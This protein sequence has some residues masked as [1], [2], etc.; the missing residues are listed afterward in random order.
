MGFRLVSMF[1]WHWHRGS[2]SL[3]TNCADTLRELL[4]A[5]SKQARFAKALHYFDKNG[6]SV[7]LSYRKLYFNESIT[8][9]PRKC[10][11]K[12]FEWAVYEKNASST[13][14][15]QAISQF[16]TGTFWM[17]TAIVENEYLKEITRWFPQ[18][19]N[20]YHDKLLFFML[21]HEAWVDQTLLC[22]PC[23]TCPQGSPVILLSDLSLDHM[24]TNPPSHVLEC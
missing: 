2:H 5:F 17:G 12:L 14:R 11:V 24:T 9:G 21:S 16:Q 10:S 18:G 3:H 8:R 4:N 19:R 15:G 22:A 1:A 23:H 6:R 20:V 13:S 7:C